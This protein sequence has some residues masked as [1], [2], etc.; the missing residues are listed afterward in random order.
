MTTCSKSND[1]LLLGHIL[2]HNFD[3]TPR[4]RVPGP[5]TGVDIDTPNYKT[6]TQ[7][8]HFHQTTRLP[9]KI[10]HK[11]PTRRQFIKQVAE[12]HLSED[13]RSTQLQY[14][15]KTTIQASNYK[16][17]IQL[18]EKHPIIREGPYYKGRAL[19]IIPY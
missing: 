3:H 8:Q 2:S 4:A 12:G 16:R 14:K 7:L 18:Q 17:S 13:K 10:V 6:S 1:S 19:Y 9:P 11:G 5:S 15:N